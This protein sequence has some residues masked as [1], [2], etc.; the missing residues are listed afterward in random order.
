M[1]TFLPAWA[2]LGIVFMLVIAIFSMFFI[3]TGFIKSV[4]TKLDR[5]FQRWDDRIKI[6]DQ[7]YM[8]QSAVDIDR[9][10]KVERVLNETHNIAGGLH[11]LITNSTKYFGPLIRHETQLLEQRTPLIYK[12]ANDTQDILRILSNKSLP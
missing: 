7:R 10:Q 4:D 5:F 8:A 3:F 12:I 9:T 11:D 1:L 6:S 2:N